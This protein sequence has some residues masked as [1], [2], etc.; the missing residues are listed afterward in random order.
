[1][2]CAFHIGAAQPPSDILFRLLKV[3]AILEPIPTHYIAKKLIMNDFSTATTHDH[4]GSVSRNSIGV[5]LARLHQQAV[6]VRQ[7]IE[8]LP[9]Q[10]FACESNRSVDIW[11]GKDRND[12]YAH[13]AV[14]H[15]QISTNPGAPRSPASL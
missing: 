3:I 7:R 15:A 14:N 11:L 9:L 1:M 4:C 10:E 13:E 5:E 6:H 12:R 8:D 2:I